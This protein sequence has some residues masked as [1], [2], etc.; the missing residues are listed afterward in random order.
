MQCR[1]WLDRKV[2]IN[3]WV[4]VIKAACYCREPAFGIYT[5]ETLLCNCNI[6]QLVHH[7]D[8]YT[9]TL[10]ITQIS[11]SL[12]IYIFILNVSF[13][14]LYDLVCA[15]QSQTFPS[16]I[17]LWWTS[18]TRRLCAFA[19]TNKEAVNKEAAPPSASK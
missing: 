4:F 15:T 16:A 3:V 2:D 18:Q 6:S 8:T 9:H 19:P 10:T 17:R 12:Y 7:D 13:R 14:S 5:N 1:S 11:L